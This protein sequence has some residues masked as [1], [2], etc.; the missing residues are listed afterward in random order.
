MPSVHIYV[1][2]KY[3]HCF[4]AF[5]LLKYIT[6]PPPSVHRGILSSSP[7]VNALPALSI[8]PPYKPPYAERVPVEAAL[9]EVL[10]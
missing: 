10:Q 1:H 3:F 9:T 5:S 2:E 4:E 6:Q 7:R 8:S